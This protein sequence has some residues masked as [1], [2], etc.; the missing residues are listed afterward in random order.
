M[1]IRAWATIHDLHNHL[2]TCLVCSTL[3]HVACWNQRV[4]CLRKIIHSLSWQSN[5][6]VDCCVADACCHC[7]QLWLLYCRFMLL[8]SWQNL[9]AAFADTYSCHSL[10]LA[11]VWTCMLLYISQTRFLDCQCMLL[12]FTHCWVLC[13][14]CTLL[15]SIQAVAAAFADACFCNPRNVDSCTARRCCCH[16][17]K[18]ALR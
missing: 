5:H 6:P 12:Q 4:N 1:A 14:R 13:C 15:S 10:R 8:L 17:H 18:Q 16:K 7:S 2:F 11:A 3:L 9:A